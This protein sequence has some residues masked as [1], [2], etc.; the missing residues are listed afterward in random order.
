MPGGSCRSKIEEY[1]QLFSFKEFCKT[2]PQ[3][4]QIGFLGFLS[5]AN[6]T[7]NFTDNA[8]HGDNL[9]TYNIANGIVAVNHY[10]NLKNQLQFVHLD[11]EEG[12]VAGPQDL[13]L[14]KHLF[15]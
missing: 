10:L 2:H 14:K 8:G 3:Y 7:F 13:E 4:K 15:N 11:H 1:F 9:P 12:Q 5:R 6:S